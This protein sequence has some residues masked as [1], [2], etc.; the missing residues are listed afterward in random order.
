MNEEEIH[1]FYD[2]VNTLEYEQAEL[3]KINS[4][5]SKAL[6]LYY[7]MIQSMRERDLKSK[8]AEDFNSFNYILLLKK[9]YIC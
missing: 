1:K 8:I 4:K 3:Y 9:M 5:Y 7:A 2:L 6:S